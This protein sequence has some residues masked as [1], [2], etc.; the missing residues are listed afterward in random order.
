MKYIVL[1]RS[2]IK[3]Q[4]GSMIGV[5]FLMLI[6]TITLS[7]ILAIWHNSDNY[8]KSEME[9]V[10]FGD[11]VYWVK[12]TSDIHGLQR[13]IES[14]KDI[15][16]VEV[17]QIAYV[18]CIVNGKEATSN[19][20]LSAYDANNYDYHIFKKSLSEYESKPDT[21]KQGEIYVPISF[22]SI[23][24]VSIGDTF[25]IKSVDAGKEKNYTIKGFYEDP[26]AGSTMLSM[27]NALISK[28]DMDILKKETIDEEN[29][30]EPA[31]CI[32]TFQSE[33]SSLTLKNLQ[34][35]ISKETNIGQYTICS[36]IKTSV[37]GF[38]LMLQN[39]FIGFLIS[40]VVILLAVS[41]IVI[42]HSIR[43]SIDQQYVDLGILKAI[44]YTKNALRF[45]KIVQYMIILCMGLVVGICFSHLLVRAIN[46]VLL[47]VTGIMTPS[48]IPV[49]LCSLCFSGIIII[50]LIVILLKIKKIGRITPITAIRGVRENF[51]R[52]NI[53]H[54]NIH[55]KSLNFWLA[56]RQLTTGVKQYIGVC[57]ITALLVFFLTLCGRIQSWMGHDGLGIMNAMGMASVDGCVYDIGIAYKDND[58]QNEVEE[59]IREITPIKTVYRTL[60]KTA[61][62]DHTNY[63][64]N[65]ISNPEYF[66]M[67]KGRYCSDDDEIVITDMVAKEM[68]L[69]IGDTVTVSLGNKK[70]DYIITGI[71]QCAIDMGENFGISVKGYERIDDGIGEYVNNYL[72]EN[73]N[74]K[75]TICEELKSKFDDRI[76]IDENEWSGMDGIVGASEALGYLMYVVSIV[77]ILIVVF[78]TGS[79]ILYQEQHNLGIYKSL[80]F[81]SKYLRI[82]FALR[83]VIVSIIGSI[84]GVL[85][86]IILTDPIVGKIFSYFGISNFSSKLS[87]ENM[88]LSTTIVILIFFLFAYLA[89]AKI[90]KT[91]PSIL[92]VE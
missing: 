42:G 77:L 73:S 12:G 49:G 23:Y 47:P 27:K 21:L 69:K 32:H 82:S 10:H 8:V 91:E 89:A 6:I 85:F 51:I 68:K 36:Y 31:Y 9:R 62:I 61:Q 67:V 39:V 60:S 14:M 35:Q 86:S 4:K 25:I 66:H 88:L 41:I 78:M 44:G 38:M 87:T 80:G 76:N 2:D 11:V 81:Q 72:F 53:F 24:D 16:S 92:I 13:E 40:F 56:L 22:K 50:I 48:T 64:M 54:F 43:S 37:I 20:I 17:E 30:I 26:T 59:L 79:K 58:I 74:E 34:E 55:R 63:L 71:N 1:L 19:V 70:A 90:R 45:V 46:R 18:K 28:E 15:N 83:F 52:H 57:I 3:K 7:S 33:D 65:V 75:D 5:F 84:L 29:N